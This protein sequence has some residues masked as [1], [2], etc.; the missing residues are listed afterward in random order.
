[1]LCTVLE[2][3]TTYDPIFILLQFDS[4]EADTQSNFCYI[5]MIFAVIV[6]NSKHLKE[7]NC[8]KEGS[9]LK[10]VVARQHDKVTL[11]WRPGGLFHNIQWY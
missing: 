10:S 11:L 9:R 1:M 2:R 5:R 8:L 6:F 7:Q 4:K 3:S